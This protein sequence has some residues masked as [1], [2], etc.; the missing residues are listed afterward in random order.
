VKLLR[1]LQ[2]GSYYPLGADQVRQSRARVVVAT[3][4][5]VLDAVAKGTFRKDLYYRL[6]THHLKLPPL[7]E[8]SGDLPLLIN[9]FVKKAAA[10]LKKPPPAVP[11]ALLQLLKSH[12]FP[13][14]LRELEAM[15]FDAVAMN[16]G[17]ELSLH[18]FR[19]A[20]T[21]R[22]D[23]D[24]SLEAAASALAPSPWLDAETLPT[25]QQAEE[26]LIAEAL[27]RTDGNQSVAAGLLGISRQALNKRLARQRH[28]DADDD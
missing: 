13:G 21:G 1:L 10:T 22:L 25:L 28:S 2:D 19:E 26:R 6:R 17:A 16:Q 14:N 18:S 3:N 27:R 20:M 24:A 12:A 4:I 8:R 15:V 9:A 23:D 11:P 5:D 7:R